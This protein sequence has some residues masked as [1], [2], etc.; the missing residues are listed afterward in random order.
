MVNVLGLLCIFD[1]Q[2]VMQCGIIVFKAVV[3]QTE[4]MQ[5]GILRRELFG[6]KL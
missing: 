2:E 1:L 3:T 5:E 4:L 6:R